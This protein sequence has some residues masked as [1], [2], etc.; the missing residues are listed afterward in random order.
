M[1][2]FT[3]GDIFASIINENKPS[4]YAWIKGGNDYPDISGM[5]RFFETPFAGIVIDVEVYGLPDISI[6]PDNKDTDNSGGNNFNDIGSNANPSS[7]YGMHIHEFGDCTPPFD[8]TGNHYN[9]DNAQHP[10][11]AG[12]MPPL[13]SSSG[14]AWMCFFDSRLTIKEVIGKSIIIHR[15]QDDFTTQPSGNS[16]EK[17]ACGVIYKN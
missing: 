4:A 13:M 5:I 3:P 16:G 9:P 11:H 12:D 1:E 14:Y 6:M 10:Q 2:D 8:K 17:I 15:M 7:F